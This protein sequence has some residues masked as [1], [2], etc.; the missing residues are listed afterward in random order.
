MGLNHAYA[1]FFVRGGSSPPLGFAKG[2][3]EI[4]K[5]GGGKKL[6]VRVIRIACGV[7]RVNIIFRSEFLLVNY[8]III[9]F[10]GFMTQ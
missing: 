10:I 5:G 6:V 7:K 8:V 4:F 2:V 1:R 3:P 9:Y